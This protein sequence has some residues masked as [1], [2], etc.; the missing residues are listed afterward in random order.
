[1]KLKEE[2]FDIES[3]IGGWYIPKK[4]CQDLITFFEKNKQR[5][6]PGLV[7]H[8]GQKTVRS[9]HK[10]STDIYLSGT[11]TIYDEYNKGLQQ[12][13]ENYM[14]RYEE[15]R[16]SYHRFSPF[17]SHFNIQ[18]YPPK[19]GYKTFHC[20]RSGTLTLKRCLVFMTYLNTVKNGGTHFK[21]QNLKTQAKEGLTL[22]WPSDFTHTH[23]GIVCNE[24]KYIVTGWYEFLD[25]IG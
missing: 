3:F 22:I 23:A 16:N 1:M 8:A 10:D 6:Q 7:F 12:C 25:D 4:V 13:L 9:E 11:D 24:T 5:H 18:K 14:D 15:T 19:G 2:K 21:Y 20:E 17:V